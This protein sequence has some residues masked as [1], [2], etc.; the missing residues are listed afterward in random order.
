MEHCSQAFQWSTWGHGQSG[1][2]WKISG[3]NI[4]YE[5]SPMLC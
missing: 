5:G 2:R 3:L 1:K 4:D